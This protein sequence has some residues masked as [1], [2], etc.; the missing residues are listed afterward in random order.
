VTRR[1]LSVCSRVFAKFQSITILAVVLVLGGFSSLYAAG[2][3]TSGVVQTVPAPGPRIWLADNQAVPV[4]TTG[5][6]AMSQALAAG[7]IQPLALATADVDGDGIADLI[8]GFGTPTGG[9]IM[10]HRGNLD[11]FAPQSTA[12][13]NA[14]GHGQFPRPFRQARRV[15]VFRCVLTSSPPDVLPPADLKTWSLPHAA[16]IPCMSSPETAKANSA[17]RK[18]WRSTAA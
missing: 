12:S 1:S 7:Q 14:I 5:A 9:M 15:S 8:A 4:K 16:A 17:R 18:W 13:F 6:A 10:V 3:Y 2:P 11:A